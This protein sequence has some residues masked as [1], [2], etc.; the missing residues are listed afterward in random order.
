MNCLM[1]FMNVTANFQNSGGDLSFNCK[2]RGRVQEHWINISKPQVSVK[3]LEIDKIFGEF[4]R[5]SIDI[6]IF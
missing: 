6:P 3:V 4:E 1:I 5:F 2:I